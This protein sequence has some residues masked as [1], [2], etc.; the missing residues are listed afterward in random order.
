MRT[1]W[2]FSTSRAGEFHGCVH[3]GRVGGRAG[4]ATLTEALDDQLQTTTWEADLV[5]GCL[6]VQ[7]LIWSQISWSEAGK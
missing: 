3:C 2:G 4:Y 7:F 6:P 1:C 5:V